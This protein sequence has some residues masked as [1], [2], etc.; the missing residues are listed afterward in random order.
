MSVYCTDKTDPSAGSKMFVKVSL[1][2]NYQFVYF[3]T[4]EWK[5]YMYEEQDIE[6]KKYPYDCLV[7]S[8]Q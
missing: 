3:L 5:I 8:I 7:S 2:V 1:N 6:R 4:N